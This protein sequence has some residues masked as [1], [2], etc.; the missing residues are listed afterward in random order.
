M[1]DTKV[2]Y[3]P[4]LRLLGQLYYYYPYQTYYYRYYPYYYYGKK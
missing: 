4:P 3:K 2:N 1:C